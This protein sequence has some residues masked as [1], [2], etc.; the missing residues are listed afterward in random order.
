MA[1][2]KIMTEGLIDQ[3]CKEEKSYVTDENDS[4][5][6]R[7]GNTVKE[8]LPLRH[9]QELK[10]VEVSSNLGVKFN[11]LSKNAEFGV[12]V[13][14]ASDSDHINGSSHGRSRGIEL[15]LNVAQSNNLDYED[16]FPPMNSHDNSKSME[17]SE[18]GST[19]GPLEEKDSKS[20]WKEMKQNG[21]I[22][23]TYNGIPPRV[24]K[25]RGRKSKSDVM[26]K[27]I[28]AAKRE[29][30]DRFARIAAPTGLL[31]R[32]NPG[33]INHVRNSKQ[34]HSII[35]ALVKSESIENGNVSIKPAIK[36]RS[37]SNEKMKEPPY[38][39]QGNIVCLERGLT[40]NRHVSG[41]SVANIQ[42]P[43]NLKVQS[44]DFCSNQID[45]RMLN[46]AFISRHGREDD[47]IFS[48]K[49]SSSSA[50]NRSEGISS[51]SSD[52]N[53]TSV[54]VLSIKAATVAS[55]WLDLL[56]QDAKGR[57]AALR[58]SK[59]RAR[60][61]IQT[62][63]PS[64]IAKEFSSTDLHDTSKLVS[65]F[66]KTD[67]A[68]LHQARWSSLFSQMETAL[69][70]EEKQLE[71]WL[72]QVKEM[73]LHCERGLQNEQLHSS[74]W[75]KKLGATG[76]SLRQE[77]INNE[78]SLAVSAAAASIYSTCSFLLNKEKGNALHSPTWMRQG[79]AATT[80]TDSNLGMPACSVESCWAILIGLAHSAIAL[81]TNLVD[82]SRRK[83]LKGADM[84]CGG[85]AAAL[86]RKQ[87]IVS[88]LCK[89]LEVDPTQFV[90]D[91]TG[92]DFKSICT[93]IL[94]SSEKNNDLK[95][96]DEVI[97]WV[98]FSEGFPSDSKAAFQVINGLNEQLGTKSV[99]LGSGLAVSEADVV[100]F[101]T[102]HS[103]VKGLSKADLQK[104]PH[105]VRWLDWVQNQKKLEGTIEKIV[106]EKSIFDPQKF[107]PVVK[108]DKESN[109]KSIAQ[110]AQPVEKTAPPPTEVDSKKPD[111]VK[112]AKAPVLKE[113]KKAAPEK[114][115]A[116][117]KEAVDNDL[118]VS[119]LNI[120]VGLIRKAW[121]HPS[122]DSLL[123]EEIDVGDAKARQVVS[124]LAKFCSP[125]DLTNR[126]VALITNVKPGKLRDVMSEGLVL[127][128]SNE[129]HTVVEPL[130]PPEGAKIGERISFTGHDGEPE[131]V[132]NP[133][134]KQLDK[135]TP[136]L[137]TDDKG[138]ATF[139]GIPFMTSGGPCTSSIP[140]ATIK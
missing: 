76:N 59:K 137:F 41:C 111:A 61:V 62:D 106:I 119:L 66:P 139:K 110:P 40:G 42:V 34:V 70:E 79:T 45:R 134:K 18:C 24:P 39:N 126:R 5:A 138:V 94:K 127:C 101:S 64:L 140:K 77:S 19:T 28:E 124:G 92:G 102:L 17:M 117:E 13:K 3:L 6:S 55:Q 84:A 33:I 109:A 98:E 69:S 1:E 81:K 85:E 12:D 57:L 72:S 46:K 121:K 114:K 135:I 23:N 129:D 71:D 63:L 136:H 35:E 78:N 104:V 21:F 54:S 116:P 37:F 122:A 32:L 14:T 16:L 75:L 83:Q 26:Q 132:L 118:S 8:T 93:S 20:I 80:T 99:L 113:E 91:I 11:S 31:N 88:C 125:D 65:K 97:K 131:A 103:F 67:M 56:N 73:Q 43:P 22:S 90:A 27:K 133:K 4:G 10:Q 44:L 115:K 48:L 95:N 36:M 25:Q 128:A 9:N 87:Q 107:M 108:V 52:D 112:K 120:Q 82:C 74:S 38:K 29:R 7:I 105:V 123:V 96:Y 30:V 53:R 100:V 58:R 51:L 50:T 15:D 130:L 2:R 89:W 86:G 47:D 60:S 68:E 49:L